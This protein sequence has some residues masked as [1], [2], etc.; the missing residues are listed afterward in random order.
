M[1]ALRLKKVRFNETCTTICALSGIISN[2]RKRNKQYQPVGW[3]RKTCNWTLITKVAWYM[4]HKK[5]P[6]FISQSGQSLSVF[7]ARSMHSSSMQEWLERQ[8]RKRDTKSPRHTAYIHD[9]C[10][11]KVSPAEADGWIFSCVA[12]PCYLLHLGSSVLSAWSF[13]F[14]TFLRRCSCFLSFH[15][16]CRYDEGKLSNALWVL[17]SLWYHC[18]FQ[19]NS[20]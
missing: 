13:L 16:R 15:F 12:L 3:E 10:I 19:G 20:A 11:I 5:M 2:V 14:K 17:F 8:A 9:S 1:K 4:A 7:L 6:Q 18:I